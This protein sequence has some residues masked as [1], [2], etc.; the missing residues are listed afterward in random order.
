MGGKNGKINNQRGGGL[1]GIRV[2]EIVIYILDVSL[3]MSARLSHYIQ[4]CC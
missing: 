2:I 3:Y 4:Y 1:F